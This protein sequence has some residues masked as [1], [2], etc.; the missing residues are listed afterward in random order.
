MMDLDSDD[1]DYDN[2]GGEVVTVLAS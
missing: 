2:G 1:D